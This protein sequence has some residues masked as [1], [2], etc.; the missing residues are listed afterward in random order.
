[1]QPVSYAA[2]IL[3]FIRGNATSKSS[4]PDQLAEKRE[5]I[6]KYEEEEE[7]GSIEKTQ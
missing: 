1:M 2:D 7:A 5:K 4:Q 3:S 6:G